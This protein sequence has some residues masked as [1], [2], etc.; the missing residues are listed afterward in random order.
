MSCYHPLTGYRVGKNMETG[1]DIIKIV[2]AI[3]PPW[4][5]Y[6]PLTIPCG[7]CIGCRLDYSRQWANRCMLELKYHERACFVTLTYDQ[8]HVRRSF[9]P[10]PDTGCAMPSLTLRKR[11]LQLFF[12][13]L[14]KRFPGTTIRYFGCGEYGPD[15]FRPHYHLIIFGIDF[16]ED[17]VFYR[18]SQTGNVM[19]TSPTLDAVWSFPPESEGSH[20]PLMSTNA[21]I[22]TIQDVTWETCA[23]TARYVT[24]KFKDERIGENGY[25]FYETF[26]IEPP[27]SVMSRRPGIGRPY[28]DDHGEIYDSSYINVSTPNGGLKF[29]PPKYFDRLLEEDDPEKYL[30]LKETRKAMAQAAQ[31]AKLA[32]TDLDYYGYLALTED[33]FQSRIKS[34]K[35]S[36][37]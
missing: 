35:R 23:Y 36:D 17:R 28:Y 11:D 32:F 30:E 14:R 18:K 25:N 22:A 3:E 13:R 12:K 20:T 16:S 7:K 34:L 26:N 10:E 29:A 24:K 19:Y 27:F 15:T 21:G 2:S 5:G 6:E 33:T 37:L 9:Y 31:E 4:K 1:K 8:F